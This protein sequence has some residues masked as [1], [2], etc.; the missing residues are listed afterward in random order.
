MSEKKEATEAELS[1]L[2]RKRDELDVRI[3]AL[4]GSQAKRYREESNDIE[5][6]FGLLKSGESLN[7]LL[8]QK[9]PELLGNPD[10]WKAFLEAKD[11]FPLLPEV[12]EVLKDGKPLAIVNDKELMVQL[13]SYDPSIYWAIPKKA[14][15]KIDEQ[16]VEATLA[17]NPSIAIW[18]SPGAQL[19]HPRLVGAAL[20]RLPLWQKGIQLKISKKLNTGV[21]SIRE[22]VLGWA[23]GGGEF[24]SSIP[25]SFLE[26]EELLLAFQGN[27]TAAENINVPVPDRLKANKAFMMKIVEKNPTCLNVVAAGLVGDVDLLVAAL[28]GKD[29]ILTLAFRDLEHFIPDGEDSLHRRWHRLFFKAANMIREKLLAHDVFVKLVLGSVRFSESSHFAALN[30][31]K[32]TSLSLEMKI[33]EYLGVPVGKELGKLRRARANL[34]LAGAHWNRS[35]GLL[36]S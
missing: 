4:E 31:D 17:W 29:G 25:Q 32:E 11:E 5:E 6:A 33:A 28:S 22:I 10:F 16:I 34:A 19:Q 12:Y 21:W 8:K 24:H 36:K 7:E 9:F 1:E 20:A 30:Q 26:D 27:K 3:A 2:K 13:C 18:L 14:P 35:K 15:L 23:K